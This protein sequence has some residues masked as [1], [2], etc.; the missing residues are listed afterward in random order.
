M[1]E[2]QLELIRS[3]Q[4]KRLDDQDL[5]DLPNQL[6]FAIELVAPVNAV[7]LSK[8]I[9]QRLPKINF[10]LEI[11]FE[12]DERPLHY[13]LTIPGVSFNFLE[14]SE[15]EIMYALQSRASESGAVKIV[16]IEPALELGF[17]GLR[18]DETDGTDGTEVAVVRAAGCFTPKCN[19]PTTDNP[20]GLAFD[21]ALQKLNVPQAKT[22][23]GVSGKEVRVAQIDTGI[24]AHDEISQLNPLDGINL[25]GEP[26]GAKD[27]LTDPEGVLNP[28]H[29]TATS[30]VLLSGSAGLVDGVAP[31]IDYLAIRAIRTVI[32]LTQWRVARAIDI[33]RRKRVHVITMSL[34]GIWSWVLRS[35]IK[36]AEAENILILAA[37]GNCVPFV[38]YPARFRD[39][40]AVAGTSP[41]MPANGWHSESA[42]VGS[43]S[44]KSVDVS[45]PG[46]FVWCASRKPMQT[47][48]NTVGAGEGTSFS[49]ALT[50]GVAALWLEEHGR[51]YLISQLAPG[52]SLMDMF[53]ISIK[54][55]ARKIPPLGDRMG[56]GIVDAEA[57]L[58]FDVKTR[59]TIAQSASIEDD[60]L[61]DHTIELLGELGASEDIGI[62]LTSS[63]FKRRIA[64]VALEIQT[65]ILKQAL[66]DWELHS[67]P[68]KLSSKAQAF[69]ESYPMIQRF[70]S[71]P[72]P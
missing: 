54:E 11:L 36:R 66:R 55:S 43:S 25:F 8:H 52:E 13:V 51:D 30:S 60:S 38:V 5:E 9:S 2:K 14:G 65:L 49:V 10:S 33:A 31:E 3:L 70:T 58:Q 64:P 21:W 20:M 29:G 40:L 68:I 4:A 7:D 69:L 56:S 16:H 71:E 27:P 39:C 12:G 63:E 28:G 18:L 34:G 6:A 23:F 35:A 44:G 26:T 24:A 17:T 1:L 37:A 32:R 15:F 53:R 57:L 72:A 67:A 50:A 42:W 48:T 41:E 45:A 62:D 61:V 46:Q 47:A 59:R 22:R 19:K